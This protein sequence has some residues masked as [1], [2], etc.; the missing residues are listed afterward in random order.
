MRIGYSEAGNALDPAAMFAESEYESWQRN[1]WAGENEEVMQL[2]TG[3]Y[4]SYNHHLNTIF[5]AVSMIKHQ[6]T[7]QM[8]RL[9]WPSQS[10]TK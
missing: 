2:S 10:R 4:E 8:E 7:Y 6:K 1:R 5:L 9:C 3:A